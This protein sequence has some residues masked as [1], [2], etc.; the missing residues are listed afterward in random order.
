VHG[1][2][3]ELDLVGQ[4]LPV[5]PVLV[6]EEGLARLLQ[7]S[8]LVVGIVL[9]NVSGFEQ[10]SVSVVVEL[11]PPVSEL[12][13]VLG[14]LVDLVESILHASHGLAVGESLNEGSELESSVRDG[15]VGLESIGRLGTLVGDVLGVRLVV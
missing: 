3:E 4:V 7:V 15:R 1:G 6:R 9:E 13:V 2:K 5:T 11:G 12:R 10:D 8:S 14:I